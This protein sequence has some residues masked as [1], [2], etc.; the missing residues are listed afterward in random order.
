MRKQTIK[1]TLKKWQKRLLITVGVIIGIVLL[2]ALFVNQYWSPIL[3]K[4]VKKTVLK[5]S[6]SLYSISF[7]DAKLH[8]LKG[9]IDIYNITFKPDTAVY[10][11]RKKLHLA[12]N[13]LFEFHVKR[14]ILYHIHPFTLYFH[15]KLDIGQVIFDEPEIMVSY[16]LNHTKDTTAKDNRTTWQKMSKSLRSVHIGQISLGDVKLKYEDYSGNKLAISELKEMNLSATDLLIDSNTQTDKSRL[17]YCK[18]IEAELNN[19][20]GRSANGLYNYK[21][22]SLRLS[23]QTSRLNIEGLDV[24][25]VKP[26]VFFDK[27]YHDRFKI[28]L[29]SLQLDHFDFLSY[30]KYRIVHG[31]YLKLGS[32][33]VSILSNPRQSPVTNRIKSFPH[34]ALQL[35][36]ADLTI[37]SINAHHIDIT[38]TEFNKKSN[39]TGTVIFKNS[40]GHIENVT[41]NKDSLQKN[42]ICTAKISSYFMNSGK[43]DVLFSFNLTDKNA[44]YTYKGSLGPMDLRLA[45]P[46]CMP[47]GLVKLNTGKLKQMDFDIKA[48]GKTARGN[49]GVLYNDLKVTVLKADTVNDRLKHMTIASLFAN[50]MVLKHDNPDDGGEKPR[51]AYVNYFRPD[52]VSFFGSIWK[53]LLAGIKPSVGLNDKMQQNVKAEIA[54]Q[55]QKKQERIIKKAVRKQRRAERKLKR[56]L[57]KELKQQDQQQAAGG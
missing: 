52:S 32:G 19:Y 33:D 13:N 28:H 14:L 25:P 30:H 23:T 56:E 36:S 44:S 43:L 5:S 35:L 47:L 22:K 31:S 20:S 8:I 50:V 41:T 15:N 57:K 51:I 49:V 16:Q 29:D 17:L 53:T 45:N 55:K 2:L 10:N 40:A 9:E 37:D 38:Y 7:S 39:K 6:D 12:P 54:D 21:L 1:A 18:D 11:R 34:F 4:E 3:A 46:A 27:T 48:N 24:S 42:N 26:E